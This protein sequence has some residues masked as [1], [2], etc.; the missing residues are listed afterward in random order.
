M[1]KIFL[2]FMDSSTTYN[3]RGKDL[4]H[5][6][7]FDNK[8][9]LLSK[10]HRTMCNMYDSNKCFCLGFTTTSFLTKS[11]HP[12]HIQPLIIR[13]NIDPL[14]ASQALI[15]PQDKDVFQCKHELMGTY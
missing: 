8:N 2:N 12:S 5:S 11:E 1:S 10:H 9:K 13:P 14:T 4:S 15:G 3:F 7:K 6:F